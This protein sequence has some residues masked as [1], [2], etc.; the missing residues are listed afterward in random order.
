MK[1]VMSIILFSLALASLQGCSNAIRIR[2]TR[3]TTAARNRGKIIPEQRPPDP[4][5]PRVLGLSRRQRGPDGDFGG[6]VAGGR[7]LTAPRSY[8]ESRIR[9]TSFGNCFPLRPSAP[10]CH[11]AERPSRTP[12]GVIRAWINEGA[13]DNPT[14]GAGGILV[15]SIGKSAYIT[16]QYSVGSPIHD[17]GTVLPDGRF[18]C[19]RIVVAAMVC[20]CA[21]AFPLGPARRKVERS[22]AG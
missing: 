1:D 16:C 6:R 2:T 7:R 3:G 12:A 20:L 14:A 8:P 22:P 19:R 5:R 21:H 15:D 10:G 13:K 18:R 9:A 17:S 11:S 4:Q